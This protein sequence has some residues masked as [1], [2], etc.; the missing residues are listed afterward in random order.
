MIG[1]LVGQELGVGIVVLILLLCLAWV[2]LTYR[3]S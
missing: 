3:R 2:F 1:G